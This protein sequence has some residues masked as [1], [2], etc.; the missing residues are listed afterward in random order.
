M[1]VRESLC[2]ESE[3]SV[4]ASL[5]AFLTPRFRL[6]SSCSAIVGGGSIGAHLII[7]KEVTSNI[8]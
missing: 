4:G 3:G 6:A 7:F 8:Q 2:G 5:S 1:V